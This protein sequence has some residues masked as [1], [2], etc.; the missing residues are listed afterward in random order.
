MLAKCQYSEIGM[1]CSTCAHA[2]IHTLRVCMEVA[3]YQL[4]C[5]N[6]RRFRRHYCDVL[7]LTNQWTSKIPIIDC[8]TLQYF[9]VLVV[10]TDTVSTVSQK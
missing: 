5:T 4:A 2:H 8:Y 9:Y 10:F 6:T 3:V 7:G 1:S